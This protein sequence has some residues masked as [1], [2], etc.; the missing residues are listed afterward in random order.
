M[1]K[2]FILERYFIFNDGNNEDRILQA[3]T[4]YVNSLVQILGVDPDKFKQQEMELLK[5][6]EYKLK[7]QIELNNLLQD[8]KVRF[9]LLL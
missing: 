5:N 1:C 9:L 7:Q 8:I 3:N 6:R 4:D 2:S